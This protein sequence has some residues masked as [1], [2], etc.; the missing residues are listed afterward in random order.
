MSEGPRDVEAHLSTQDLAHAID[1]VLRTLPERTQ[2]AFRLRLDHALTNPE[3]AA[4]M[5]VT[6]KGVEFQMA[7]AFRLLRGALA[8]L[9]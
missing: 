9:R 2:F 7:K 6:V 4:V 1:T 3:I 5:G 8:E